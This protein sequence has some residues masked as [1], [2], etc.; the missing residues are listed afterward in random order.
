MNTYFQRKAKEK[1]SAFFQKHGK[2][3]HTL[4]NVR[5]SQCVILDPG[6]KTLYDAM[7]KG[8][9]VKPINIDDYVEFVI[10]H[11]DIIHR[12]FTLDKI[13]DPMVAKQNTDYLERVVG[14]KPIPIYHIQSPIEALQEIV[15]EGHDVISIGGSALRSVSPQKREAAFRAILERF[16]DDVNFYALGLGSIKHLLAF[17]WF[18]ADASSWLNARIYGKLTT[19]IGIVTTPRLMSLRKPLDSM[20]GHLQP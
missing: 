1:E 8:R 13:G 9:D 2:Q 18:S 4:L 3:G 6:E 20:C 17:D 7:S 14:K 11:S 10:R 16:G 12:Y 15:N 19:L 5:D